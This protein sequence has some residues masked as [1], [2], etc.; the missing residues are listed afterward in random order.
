MGSAP[1]P[2]LPQVLDTGT[3]RREISAAAGYSAAKFSRRRSVTTA[4]PTQSV[5]AG[6]VPRGRRRHQPEAIVA[7]YFAVAVSWIFLSDALLVWALGHDRRLFA[8]AEVAKGVGFVLVTGAVLRVLLRNYL[9]EVRSADE[10][11]LRM[12]GFVER[13]P[14]AVVEFTPDGQVVAAN[15]AAIA[16]ADSLEVPLAEFVP[17]AS[18][19]LVRECLASGLPSP[20]FDSSLAGRSWR[21]SFFPAG[22]PPG[23]YGYGHERTAEVAL[24]LQIE[25]SARM[26]SVGRLAA[27]VAHDLGNMLMAIAGHHSLLA[28]SIPQDAA[29]A[30]EMEGI[31]REMDRAQDL[32]R[33]LMLVARD[34][35]AGPRQTRIDVAAALPDIIQTVRHMVPFNVDL[36]VRTQAETCWIE[37]DL[38]GLE[39]AVL[40]LVANAV[41]VMPDGGIIRLSA[42]TGATGNLTIEVSDSGPGIPE[43]VLPR[44]FDPFFTTKSEGHG[45]G[46]GLASVYALVTECGGIVNVQSLPGEGATFSLVLP[47]LGE[48]S[49]TG[50]PRGNGAP[51]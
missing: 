13:T 36:Q 31:R 33:K 5:G 9:A 6:R 14:D 42:F 50:A 1:G 49:L 10:R 29:T 21:W 46:L 34:R 41:D 8:A 51:A 39:R 30:E 2:L 20:K 35:P 32:V 45:T 7:A 37:V 48:P 47:C 4:R 18:R 3:G 40:N 23:A 24:H 11:T 17:S 38:E 43:D 22:D 15:A 25:R 12:A 27:G 44:I 19:D 16:A 28:L 26:E